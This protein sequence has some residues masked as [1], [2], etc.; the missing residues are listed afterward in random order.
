L[1]A[2]DGSQTID[3]KM[4]R[5]G[6]RPRTAR[7]AAALACAL[8]LALALAAPSAG[9]SAFTWTTGSPTEG[10]SA[11]TPDNGGISC[12][13]PTQCTVVNTG[14][15]E[16]TFNPTT[17][18]TA[19]SGT[20]IDSGESL[21]SV[22][23][24]TTS[25][26]TAVD[27]TGGHQVT[28]D[29]ASPSTAH[30]T[31][32]GAT[33]PF[34]SLR[35][36]ACPSV[37]RCVAVKD[38]GSEITFNPQSPPNV[39]GGTAAGA[40]GGLRAIACPATNYCAAVSDRGELVTFDPGVAGFSVTT[41]SP[42]ALGSGNQMEGIACPSTTQCTAVDTSGYVL[43]FNPSSPGTPARVP[44]GSIRLWGIAC[45]AVNLC[46]AADNGGAAVE[47]NPTNASSWTAV[48]LHPT[49]GQLAVAC[50]SASQC[51]TA[52]TMSYVYVGTGSATPPGGNPGGG[53]PGGGNPGGVTPGGGAPNPPNPA[54][55]EVVPQNPGGGHPFITGFA[56]GRPATT[57]VSRTGAFTLPGTTATCAP[58]A[59]ACTLTLDLTGTI[60]VNRLVVFGARLRPTKVRLGSSKRTLRPN[61]SVPVAAKLSASGLKALI[62]AKRLRVS[63]L[64][65]LRQGTTRKTTTITLTLLAPK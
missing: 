38:G 62:K 44:V 12:P 19:S 50:S 49:R 54:P 56:R 17:A 63:I 35:G 61:T 2:R 7:H 43:T 31:T 39:A 34:N 1:T 28:F 41:I 21:S 23:C 57:R 25:Q 11:S 45:P 6:K 37:T 51:V 15:K 64:L 16:H 10:S 29:P 48:P 8:V 55:T 18:I 58:G 30:L 3:L 40:A 20:T 65:T 22:S 36:V 60:L 47:G 32:I 27:L 42:G 33:G 5:R 52:A 9:A 59:V 53:D 26:C 13:S 14:G 46:V 4:D 24:P